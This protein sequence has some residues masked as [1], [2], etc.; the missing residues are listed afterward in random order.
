M[1]GRGRAV[2]SEGPFTCNNQPTFTEW[3][4]VKSR[5]HTDKNNRGV[6]SL[7]LTLHN[8][9]VF[10]ASALVCLSVQRLTWMFLVITGQ[11]LFCIVSSAATAS[12]KTFILVCGW[13]QGYI[14]MLG[15][16][17]CGYQ[18]KPRWL[19]KKQPY[20]TS[21]LADLCL[22]DNNMKNNNKGHHLTT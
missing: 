17:F 16:D 4:T 10:W 20:L 21:T 5:V 14:R 19:H 2:E 18:S 11:F 13:Q 22:K 3:V 15:Q 8:L 1:G 9:T 7:T 6:F 12:S